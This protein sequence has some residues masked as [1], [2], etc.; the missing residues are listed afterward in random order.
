M[1]DA[2]KVHHAAL[3]MIAA[4]GFLAEGGAMWEGR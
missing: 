2:L 3:P 4:G 1:H